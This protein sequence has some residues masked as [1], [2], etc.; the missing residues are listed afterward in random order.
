MSAGEP[1]TGDEDDELETT[2]LGSRR[3]RRELARFEETV[4][5]DTVL[6]SRPARDG[7][8]EHADL[9][10]LLEYTVVGSRPRSAAGPSAELVDE[11]LI[12]Q[13]ARG[14]A[15]ADAAPLDSVHDTTILVPVDPARGIGDPFPA[16]ADVP[17]AAEV[18]PIAPQHEPGTRRIGSAEAVAPEQARAA[19]EPDRAALRAPYRPR[20]APNPQIFRAPERP[21]PLQPTVLEH[22]PTHGRPRRGGVAV[23]IVLGLVMVAAIAGIVLLLGA[24]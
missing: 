8:A 19:A 24:A 10:E 23:A 13:R 4:A 14:S 20:T 7:R 15:P 17:A 1:G 22:Q 11:T 5:E 16:M 18:A 6:G 2:T 3:V 9:P 21:R 12:G